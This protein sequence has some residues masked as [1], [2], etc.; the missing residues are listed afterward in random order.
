M[1]T[2]LQQTGCSWNASVTAGNSWL[3]CN[4]SGVGDGNIDI[5]VTE[6]PT[7]SPRSGTIDVAGQALYVSQTGS[8][9]TYSLSSSVFDCP[10][11]AG[12]TFTNVA[13]VNTFIGCSWM[14]SVTSGSGW[15]TTSSN[16]TASGAITIYVT[17]N[18]S[19]SPRV[20]TI[21]VN[22]E[23]LTVNQPGAA[24]PQGINELG[25]SQFSVSPNPT[26]GELSIQLNGNTKSASF[27]IYN[28]LGQNVLT[29]NLTNQTTIV[30]LE[31]LTDGVYYLSLDGNIK[32]PVKIIKD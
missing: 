4:S 3:T 13:L 22:G 28:L 19:Y 14:A 12:N 10:S 7:T 8:N 6:N 5:S 15:I 9:C 29:G 1:Y 32:H 11:A 16:G 18:T 25:N 24:W 21:D 30:N 17:P 31:N 27:S 23:T 20:A 2:G 26:N